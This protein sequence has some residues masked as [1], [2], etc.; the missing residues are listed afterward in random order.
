MKYESLKIE[1]KYVGSEIRFQKAGEPDQTKKTIYFW[2]RRRQ[3]VSRRCCRP[4]NFTKNEEE[5]VVVALGV[6]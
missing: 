5:P 6:A 2:A 4:R 3:S 1:T